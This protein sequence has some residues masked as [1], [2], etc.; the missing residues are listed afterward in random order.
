MQSS[1]WMKLIYLQQSSTF[2]H[3]LYFARSPYGHSFDIFQCGNHNTTSINLPSL[4][5]NVKNTPQFRRDLTH[6]NLEYNFITQPYSPPCPFF[7]FSHCEKKLSTQI[8]ILHIFKL[9]TKQ[10]NSRAK[11]W[12]SL[13]LKTS[14]KMQDETMPKNKNQKKKLKFSSQLNVF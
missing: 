2:V 8:H 14:I 10:Y 3:F 5:M 9:S 13:K 11:P 4:S 7:A 12:V 1:K 6:I